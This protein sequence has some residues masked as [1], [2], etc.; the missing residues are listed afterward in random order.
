MIG[1]EIELEL[2]EN[3][4]LHLSVKFHL[5]SIRFQ[6]YDDMQAEK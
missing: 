4:L 3:C 2:I 1:K 6:A 5:H